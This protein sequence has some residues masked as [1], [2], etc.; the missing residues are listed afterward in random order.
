MFHHPWCFLI[1]QMITWN[2]ESMFPHDHLWKSH[3]VNSHVSEMQTSNSILVRDPLPSELGGRARLCFG[4]LSSGS[5]WWRENPPSA[6][7]GI[8][9]APWR[10]FG[11]PACTRLTIVIY[12]SKVGVSTRSTKWWPRYFA[13]MR[14]WFANGGLVLTFPKTFNM[15]PENQPLDKEKTSSV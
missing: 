4:R 9:W 14:S 12:I 1:K 3:V 6:A 10:E 11:R 7:R 2:L 15:E 13:Q 8:D 5:L